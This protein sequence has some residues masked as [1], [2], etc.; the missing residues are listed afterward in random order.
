[1]EIINLTQSIGESLQ[2]EILDLEN[3]KII[4]AMQ[5]KRDEKYFYEVHKYELVNEERVLW[6]YEIGQDDFYMHQA[7]VID[8]HIIIV[9][10]EE[11]G[12][13]RVEVLDK[14]NGQLVQHELMDI[15]RFVGD[16][17]IFI[18]QDYFLVS[19]DNEE[20]IYY[21]C[22]ISEGKA[23]QVWDTAF[24]QGVVVC[25][26]LI[27][28]MPVFKHQGEEWVVYNECYMSDY[29]YEKCGEYVREKIVEA[30]KIKEKEGL[31]I[32]P[33]NEF[34]KSIKEKQIISFECIKQQYLDGWVRYLWQD[35]EKIYY[36]V[37]DFE[38]QI[39]TIY[40]MNFK[41][42]AQ[43]VVC[44]INH[45]ALMG[46][47]V[48]NEGMIYEEVRG[49]KHFVKGYMGLSEKLN[50]PVHKKLSF[51]T[52]LENSYIITSWWWERE[53]NG[54]YEYK[55]FVGIQEKVADKCIDKTPEDQAEQM[56]V[57]E[58]RVYIQD[59]VLIIY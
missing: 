21:L 32:V 54:D 40:T 17:V 33:L 56:L 41:D 47:L 6:R 44:K 38:T 53:T 19:C 42:L 30:E 5:V 3:K 26:G 1:M 49:E 8:N 27:D 24:M 14:E 20:S 15:G 22:D 10:V 43:N 31:Y 9:G 39:E 25:H 51:R 2:T 29:E 55:E 12:K 45:T 18:N 57:Y 7:K 37:K 59:N 34:I 46:E 35:E 23:Y 58:G 16:R 36:R 28:C 48:Y 4:F 50:L 11:R 13:V 52:Y